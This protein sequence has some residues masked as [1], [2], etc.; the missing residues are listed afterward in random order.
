MPADRPSGTLTFIGNATVLVRC[1]GFTVLTDPNFLHAGE[2]ASLGYG[3]T[4]KRLRDPAVEVDALP[5]LDAVVLSHLHGDHFDRVARRGLA[6]NLPVVTT[7]H[8]ARVL[9]WWGFER[10]CGMQT[11]DRWSVRNAD[12]GELRVTALP[13]RHAFGAL[14]V[15]LPPV[16]GSLLEFREEPGGAAYRIYLTGDTLVHE[17][18]REIP[19][20]HPDIDLGLL[21]LGGTKV[22]GATVTMD[23]RQGVDLLELVPVPHAVP[24]HYDDYPVFRSPLSDFTA[25]VERRRP[26]ARISYMER[27]EELP[28][29]GPLPAL[30]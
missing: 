11:W 3:L 25:E 24:V 16:N 22:L 5:P 7:R 2:R 19:R 20:R 17:Q 12:G 30:P 10:A 21:H 26:P 27:G 28:L 9:R 29:P 14:G 23:G 15:L 6:K 18:L 8:A 4:S 13:A 1:A